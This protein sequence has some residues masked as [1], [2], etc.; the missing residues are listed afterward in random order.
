MGQLKTH[1]TNKTFDTQH[2]TVP[3]DTS[4]KTFFKTDYRFLFYFYILCVCGWV[5]LPMFWASK[6]PQSTDK[7]GWAGAPEMAVRTIHSSNQRLQ[8]T[9]SVQTEFSCLCEQ[10]ISQRGRLTHAC[11]RGP[12]GSGKRKTVANGG[13]SVDLR[14]AFGG[15]FQSP[16]LHALSGTFVPDAGK[17]ANSVI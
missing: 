5:Y 6:I 2:Y 17:C 12:A 9:C 11:A 4:K 13:P 7:T 1:N 3:V 14:L 10:V 8:H 16:K 15:S